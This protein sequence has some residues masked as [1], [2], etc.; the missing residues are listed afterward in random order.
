MK[1]K[2]NL[3][4]AVFFSASWWLVSFS[5]SEAS[6]ITENKVLELV[7]RS[8]VESGLGILNWN[9]KLAQ[10]AQAKIEDMLAENYFSHV[11]PNGLT[12]W[13][14]I[15]KSGYAYSLAGENLAINFTSAENQHEAWMRS[16]KHQKNILNA[17]Y[18]ELGV[19]VAR[20][21]IDGQETML[22][23]QMFGT[24]QGAVVKNY[25]P[26]VIASAVRG[27]NRI[28]YA[29]EETAQPIAVSDLARTAAGIVLM[30]SLVLAPLTL[31]LSNLPTIH[32][33]LAKKEDSISIP[34]H[35][36]EN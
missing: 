34:V 9:D 25:Q 29:Q 15:E 20:G 19:A 11:S 33:K 31:I 28:I 14:W 13:E 30:L 4:L 26:P 24:P 10:A 36:V 21:K 17:E 27:A 23:V 7:N 1:N 8:R 18:Q 16:A 22:T 12:P 3:I 5:V 2:K 6:V 35:V 32:K